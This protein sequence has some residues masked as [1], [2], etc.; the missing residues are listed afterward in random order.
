VHPAWRSAAAL[1][2]LFTLLF[3]YMSHL[4]KPTLRF[5][6]FELGPF[7]VYTMWR[8]L[9]VDVVSLSRRMRQGRR[10]RVV[11]RAVVRWCPHVHMFDPIVGV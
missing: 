5:S 10:R 2:Y 4:P 3:V 1:L 11:C 6:C 8:T 9:Q 7:L